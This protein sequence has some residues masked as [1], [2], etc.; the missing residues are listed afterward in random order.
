MALVYLGLVEG[1]SRRSIRGPCQLHANR[2]P[3]NEWLKFKIHKDKLEYRG[4]KMKV[5]PLV[6]E[7]RRGGNASFYRH[8]LG[9][10]MNCTTGLQSCISEASNAKAGTR[11]PIT[12]TVGR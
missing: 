4:Q 3:L 2:A 5:G 10:L 11:T 8:F 1:S 7:I 9:Y 12:V 6:V